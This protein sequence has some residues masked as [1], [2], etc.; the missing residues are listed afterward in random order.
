MVAGSRSSR[1]RGCGLS[2]IPCHGLLAI[3]YGTIVAEVACRRPHQP[4][5]FEIG[6]RAPSRKPGF[7][8][9]YHLCFAVCVPLIGSSIP[10]PV[11]PSCKWHP[12]PHRRIKLAVS[13][14]RFGGGIHGLGRLCVVPCGVRLLKMLWRGILLGAGRGL[15]PSR[16]DR[17][18]CVV[19]HR[20]ALSRAARKP[21][22]HKARGTTCLRVSDF[23]GQLRS[24][25]IA[26]EL[27]RSSHR[28][29]R[30][31]LIQVGL[32]QEILLFFRAVRCTSCAPP[33][34][35]K[36]AFRPFLPEWRGHP[37]AGRYLQTCHLA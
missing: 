33:V 4:A 17:F 5:A 25:P 31:T 15:I 37:T 18:V 22:T 34:R 26:D 7:A 21:E 2:E 14:H 36:C 19:C 3:K 30:V 8:S 12:R 28:G 32:R 23:R 13:C 20:H 24:S 11:T 10:Q 6:F 29:H 35:A 16:F 27:F 9:A 1:V